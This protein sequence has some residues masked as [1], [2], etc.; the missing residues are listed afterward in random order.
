MRKETFLFFLK[1]EGGLK[2]KEKSFRMC[3]A[4]YCCCWNRD[5]SSIFLGIAYIGDREWLLSV[6]SSF[7][8]VIL[9]KLLPVKNSQF[10]EDFQESKD[11]DDFIG[12]KNNRAYHV[13]ELGV[14]APPRHHSYSNS[15]NSNDGE[16]HV[17]RDSF[18]MEIET[19]A[20]GIDSQFQQKCTLDIKR[21]VRERVEYLNSAREISAA[22]KMDPAYGDMFS[23]SEAVA[24]F[25]SFGQ[26]RSEPANLSVFAITKRK[27]RRK[28]R[29]SARFLVDAVFFAPLYR[30]Q[31][32][33]RLSTALQLHLTALMPELSPSQL[34]CVYWSLARLEITPI[35]ELQWCMEEHVKAIRKQIKPRN[36]IKM[37][38]AVHKTRNFEYETHKALDYAM[39]NVAKALNTQVDSNNGGEKIKPKRARSEILIA[40]NIHLLFVSTRYLAYLMMSSNSSHL[41]THMQGFKELPWWG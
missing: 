25:W 39:A 3:E 12:G 2:K 40:K 8:P 41:W 36:F 28:R 7:V 30:Y 24:L 33:G 22:H 9:E 21:R 5:L 20:V 19:S 10:L 38:T 27:R 16:Q 6:L 37:M 14:D 29:K 23:A 13:Q 34:T 31:L 32:R 15:S 26:M 11:G 1:R 4:S 18:A 35:T 17:A